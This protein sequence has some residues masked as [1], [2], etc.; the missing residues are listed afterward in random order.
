M[1]TTIDSPF[2]PIDIDA[3][4]AQGV[5]SIAIIDP[6]IRAVDEGGNPI[7]LIVYEEGGRF[8]AIDANG[9]IVPKGL[10]HITTDWR[11]DFAKER[12]V[13][14]NGHDLEGEGG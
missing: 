8:L 10:N 13:D 9:K 7:V 4:E 6:A 12:W 1:A 3:R 5:S 11:Y 2:G 14:T